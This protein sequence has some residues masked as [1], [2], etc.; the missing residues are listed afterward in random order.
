VVHDV[1]V[2]FDV[3]GGDTLARSWEVAKPGGVLV[4]VVSPRPTAL[5]PRSDVRFVWFI[6][7]PSGD[8]LRQIGELIDAE[9]ILPIVDRTLPL[10]EARRAFEAA[11]QEHPRGK[12]V[13]KIT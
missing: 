12:I 8:Q 10:V 1:D 9:D 7:E 11:A 4:S 6:V 5:A 13:L 2:I 3:V